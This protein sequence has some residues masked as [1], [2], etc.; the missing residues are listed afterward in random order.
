V[1]YDRW[2][3]KRATHI[4]AVSFN[5]KSLLENLEQVPVE[6]ITV[7]QHGIPAALINKNISPTEVQEMKTKYNLENAYPIVGVISRFVPEKG[8]QY[9]IPA[10]QKL[11]SEFPNAKLILANAN[12]RYA[13]T[14]NELLKSLPSSSFLKIKFENN[15][16]PLFKAFDVFVHAPIDP[17]CEAFGQ[18]YIEAM[19]L[20]VPMVCTL[21][22]I[23]RDVIEHEKNA[24]VADYKNTDSLY[25]QMRRM[26]TEHTLRENL[27]KQAINDLNELTFEIKYHKIESVYT[28]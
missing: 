1:K 2:V 22:G 17:T 12:G 25:Q 20:S 3:N 6:K 10:F 16:N 8:I 21:S 9:T 14:I 11:L 7:I 23:A 26:L 24:L 19:S 5:I 4:I 27:V 28:A 15:I 18:V 13:D